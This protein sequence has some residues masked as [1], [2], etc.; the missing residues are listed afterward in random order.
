MQYKG[1]WSDCHVFET[2]WTVVCQAPPSMGFS[3]QEY[4]NG[5]PFPSP[6]DLP[7]PGIEPKS[8]ALVADSS[9]FEPLSMWA[10]NETWTFPIRD[11]NYSVCNKTYISVQ[12]SSVGQ[13]CPTLCDPMKHSTPGYPVH[14][15][16]PEYT[17]INVH[18]VSDAIQISHPLSFPSPPAPIPPSIR[19]FS[20]ESVLPIR[21]PKNWNFSFNIRPSNEH[22]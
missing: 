18:W 5:F 10:T 4:W 11:V 16:L 2:L 12:F 8:P 21:W 17:Q 1:E 19:V 14:H 6:G 3:R 15:Q 7:V 22:P 13:S 20:N 9:L